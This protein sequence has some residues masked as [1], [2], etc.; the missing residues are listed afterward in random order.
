[1]LETILSVLGS[2]AGGGFLGIF[3]NFLKARSE[4][5]LAKLRMD[6]E[7]RMEE[8]GQE[9]MRLESQLK[10]QQISLENEGQALLANIEAVRSKDVGDAEI[11]KASYQMDKASYGGG[12]VDTIRGLTRPALTLASVIMLG[13]VIFKLTTLIGGMDS[14][15]DEYLKEL[16]AQVLQAVIFLSTASFAW[17]FGARSSGINK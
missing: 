12:F 14:F 6:Q 16:Y 15:S 10:I 7:I 8:L 17:W 4:I 9:S 3:G 2:A 5:K 1:M 13:Y 11:Q